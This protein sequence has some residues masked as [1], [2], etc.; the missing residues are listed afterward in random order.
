[1]CLSSALTCRLTRCDQPNFPQ[2]LH[3]ATLAAWSDAVSG[4]HHFPSLLCPSWV[5]SGMPGHFW[6]EPSQ[7]QVHCSAQVARIYSNG[8]LAPVR[9]SVNAVILRFAHT[10]GENYNV[11]QCQCTTVPGEGHFASSR[12]PLRRLETIS[13]LSAEKPHLANARVPG[14]S[15]QHCEP[16]MDHWSD[17]LRLMY[18]PPKEMP[19]VARFDIACVSWS[20]LYMTA[21]FTGNKPRTVSIF[22]QCS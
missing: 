6:R 22:F 10:E 3:A 16:N 12:D 21:T 14:M 1:M 15:R 5:C 8:S 20:H 11:V 9:S 17:T 18:I 13:L 7:L 19:P 4:S 2:P